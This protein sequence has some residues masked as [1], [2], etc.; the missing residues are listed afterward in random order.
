MK[1]MILVL[2]VL[3]SFS[4]THLFMGADPSSTPVDIFEEFW[5]GVDKTW[6][7]FSSKHVNWDSVYNV[8]RPQVSP[9]TNSSDLRKILSGLL[10]NLKDSHT[11]IF[12]KGQPV[13]QY[14][15]SY[16]PNFYGTNWIGR[17]YKTSYKDN[18]TISYGL[19][20]PDIGY[21]YIVSFASQQSD[22]MII[23]DILK[24]FGNVKG[25]IIDVRSNTGGNTGNSGLIAGRFADQAR[26]FSYVRFRTGSQKEVLSGFVSSSIGPSGSVRFRNKVAVLTNKYSYSAAEEFVLMMKSF[27]QVIQIGDNTGGGSE[28]KPILKELPGGW[29]YRVSGELLCGLDQQPITKGIVPDIFVQTSKIDSLN[30]KD[31]II[32]RAMLELLK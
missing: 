29:S 30:G 13:I 10:N 32:E 22:Y 14:Y 18:R 16:P 26:T 1:K 24:G 20:N 17:N 23:D 11:G 31:S 21:I 5:K 7:A 3:S 9:T 6:P 25:V 2:L 8:Y 28:S 4:C 19:L 15:P 27:P 12:P